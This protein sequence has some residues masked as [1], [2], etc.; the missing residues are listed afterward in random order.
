MI[1]LTCNGEKTIRKIGRPQG[2][3]YMACQSCG[4]C[5]RVSAAPLREFSQTLEAWQIKEIRRL[6]ILGAQL[7]AQMQRHPNV[8]PSKLTLF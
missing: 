4:V 7:F 1:C 6:I 5:E 3:S 8:L 2:G